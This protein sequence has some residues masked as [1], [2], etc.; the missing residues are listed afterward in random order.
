MD[1]NAFERGFP[2]ISINLKLHDPANFLM[3]STLSDLDADENEDD[4][5]VPQ[6]GESHSHAYTRL[7]IENDRLI[8]GDPFASEYTRAAVTI[9]Q[10]LNIR[11]KYILAQSD[12]KLNNFVVI[13]IKVILCRYLGIRLDRDATAV[14]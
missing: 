7:T 4:N 3:Q 13:D 2:Q 12:C 14:F 1:Q 11:D 6:T 10:L 5:E 9:L 8:K